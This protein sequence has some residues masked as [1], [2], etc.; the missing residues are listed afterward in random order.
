MPPIPR[1]PHSDDDALRLRQ[2][3]QTSQSWFWELDARLEY[4]WLSPGSTERMGCDAAALLG[5]GIQAAALEP[6]GVEAHDWRLLDKAM[7]G[8]QPFKEFTFRVR[9]KGGERLWHELTGEPVFDAHGEFL[10]YRGT[11]R[12]ATL[13]MEQKIAAST[14]LLVAEAKI[15]IAVIL[16]DIGRPFEQRCQEALARLF[17]LDELAVQMRGGMFVRERGASHLRLFVT[18]GAFS[19]EFLTRE[20]WVPVGACLCG[21]AA[22]DGCIIVS[23]NCF[24]DPGHA[25]VFTDMSAHG[26]YILPLMH[27]VESIGVLFLYTSPY[28][29]RDPQRLQI[30]EQIAGLFTQALLIEQ[31]Y[32]QLVRARVE[33]EAASR[34]KSDFLANMSHEIRTPMNGVIG[35]T[36]LLLDTSLDAEQ[37]EFA[38]TVSNSAESLLSIINDILDFSKVEAGR[39]ELELIEFDPRESIADTVDI[40]AVK[41]R[42]KGLELIL[43]VDEQVPP[44]LNGDPGRLRQVLTNLI[45]N[46]I[47]FTP[48]GEVT[49]EVSVNEAT[50]E[51]A[52]LRFVVRDTGIGIPPE[53]QNSLFQ[54]FSQ[55]DASHTRLFGGTGLGLSIAQRLVNLMDG[56]IDLE[57]L[58]GKGSRFSFTASFGIV[59]RPD[60]ISL[61]AHDALLGSRILAVDDNETNR[62]LIGLLLRRWG[63]TATILEHPRQVLPAIHAAR[64]AGQPFDLAVLDVQ[65]PDEDGV[66]LGRKIAAET[67]ATKVLPCVLLS[68]V[69]LNASEASTE[70]GGFAA[71]LSKPIRERSLLRTLTGL[72]RPAPVIGPAPS[73]VVS[74]PVPSRAERILLVEDNLTNQRLAMTMLRRQGFVVD[75]ANNGAEALDALIKQP[76]D[77][78]LM[79]CQMPVMD[80]FEATRRIRAIEA[81]SRARSTPI[82]ALTADALDEARDACASAGMNDFVSKP[83][84]KDALLATIE[85][86]LS[87]P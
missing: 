82:I 26:H 10:G 29:S 14:A 33:A 16:Q 12:Q 5:R 64:A 39:L 18:T 11:G 83:I 9:T 28:P 69:N 77:L 44:R 75:V 80:G 71:M 43:H 34:A 85:D 45:G 15:D 51:Q 38:E 73:E 65:M 79:D 78:V 13:R 49:V 48:S 25:H 58:P 53:K 27:G 87:T 7:A 55:V 22:R 40:L 42:E 66:S 67:S 76:Y 37:R 31:S 63:A 24:D 52:L 3:M 61:P 8:R 47:K 68:S 81:E 41:A 56:D 2:F 21:R 62:R 36:Q 35:M 84:N 23:D 20:A 19:H 72:L 60:S 50:D 70:A 6:G 32:A 1:S 59:N 54:P 4:V 74:Q 46:A 57:S 30:L 17:T 86:W